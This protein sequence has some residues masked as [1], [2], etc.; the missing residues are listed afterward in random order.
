MENL[1]NAL[2]SNNIEKFEN[3]KLASGRKLSKKII[4]SLKENLV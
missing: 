3:I 2:K 4:T 1:L